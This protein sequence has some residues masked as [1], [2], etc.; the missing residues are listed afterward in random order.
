M[1]RLGVLVIGLILFGSATA[2]AGDVKVIANSSVSA[3]RFG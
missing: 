3:F 2:R 1:N